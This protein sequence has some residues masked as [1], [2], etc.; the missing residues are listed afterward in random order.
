MSIKVNPNFTITKNFALTNTLV[1]V[2]SGPTDLWGWDLVNTNAAITYVQMFNVDDIS[3]VT[4][5]TTTPDKVITIPATSGSQVMV[6]FS[7]DEVIPFSNG[8]VIVATTTATGS[9]A[10]SS[11]IFANISVR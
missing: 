4:L 6:Q 3:K 1:L 10:P 11:A 8:L 2:R 7:K 9:S 5:G